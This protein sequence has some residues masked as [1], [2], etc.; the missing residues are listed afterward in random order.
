MANND[1]KS[2]K[3]RAQ[4][5]TQDEKMSLVTII[6]KFGEIIECKQTHS[7]SKGDKDKA[8][9]SVHEE[10][11]V[12]ADRLRTLDMLK[13]CWNNLKKKGGGIKNFKSDRL[14]EKILK[15][16]GR[17]VEPPKNP[18]DSDALFIVGDDDDGLEDPIE[19]NQ[20]IHRYLRDSGQLPDW[21][22]MSVKNL[23]KPVKILKPND[24]T[25]L[26][27]DIKKADFVDDKKGIVDINED[28]DFVQ[29]HEFVVLKKVAENSA[30]WK[31]TRITSLNYSAVIETITNFLNF[32]WDESELQLEKRID[33]QNQFRSSPN[34]LDAPH[35]GINFQ[36]ETVS[37]SEENKINIDIKRTKLH[38]ER[39]KLKR[40]DLKNDLLQLQLEKKRLKWEDLKNNLE[41]TTKGE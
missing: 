36:H 3:V 19:G 13:N 26:K 34:I 35:D 27:Q 9:N 15:V 22:K 41:R 2:T 10:Y 31:V 28:T 29:L 25:G 30:P 11:N 16:I 23:K 14:M 37:C 20:A 7:T 33:M 39:L 8:W 24:T 4:N 32:V 40:L 5:F 6:Q 18:Y 21:S 38:K 12:N 1:T 17:Q